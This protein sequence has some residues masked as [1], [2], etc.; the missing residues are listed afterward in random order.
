MSE[1]GSNLSVSQRLYRTL[2][3]WHFYAGIFCIPFVITLSVS[4]ALYLFKPQFEAFTDRHLHN[5]AAQQQQRLSINE[6][7]ARAR[8]SLPGAQFLSYE[9]PQ[10]ERE[11]ALVNLRFEG[12]KYQVFVN[13]YSGEVLSQVLFDQRFMRQVREFHGELMA[14]KAGSI[15][16]ELAACWAIILILTGVYLWWPRNAQG[17]AGVLYPR[18]HQ[19]KR[20]FWRDL[21]AVT[22]FWLS[23][24]TLFL[25]LSGL[26]WALVWGGAFKEVRSWSSPP[27]QQD[28]NQSRAEE[29]KSW[30]PM[31]VDNVFISEQA[32]VQI[33]ALNFAP[34]VEVSVADPDLGTLKVSS[35][36]QNRPLR[37]DAWI[38]GTSGEVL[39]QKTF[40]E[41]PL[42]DKV[43]GVG[44]AAHEGHLF[45]WLNQ[46]LGV[47]VTLGLVLLSVTG[48]VLWWR[49]KP[50]DKLG[51][52]AALPKTSLARVVGIM[53]LALGVL[54]PVVG[55][56][57]LVLWFIEL[58]I[59][60]HIPRLRYWFGL[61]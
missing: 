6:V 35:Q 53:I 18:L 55:I 58:V 12:Q 52:P 27:V 48:A 44:I 15:L 33:E 59:L 8:A 10:S 37:A 50:S 56:S 13:P 45:G 11:A 7:I 22:G 4:G 61:A 42:V 19:S 39:R 46:L 51:A 29:K 2:W 14:G 26:P 21:H 31:A 41:R 49:R 28:W 47:L 36:A 16:V 40:A 9:L 1:R 20:I 34:P 57:L 60:R 3:R 54:L 24:F 38:D 17:M 23:A 43:I 25:L 32:L 30:G 5:I